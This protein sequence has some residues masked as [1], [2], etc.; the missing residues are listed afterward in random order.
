MKKETLNKFIEI[1]DSYK[2][3]YGVVSNLKKDNTGKVRGDYKEIK[4]ELTPKQFENHLTGKGYGLRLIALKEN[5]KLRYAALDLDKK[6]H[7]S[8]LKHS[9]EEIEKKV[10]QLGL[11][12]IPCRSKSGDVHL[13]CFASEDVDAEIFMNKMAE[14]AGLLGYGGCERFPKQTKRASREDTGLALNLPYFNHEE[15]ERY[16]IN[17]GKKLSLEEFIKYANVSQVTEE[18]LLNFKY[19]NFDESYNDAPPC[20]QI[21]TTKQVE[22]GGRNNGLFSFAVYYA[23][24]YPDNFEEKVMEAN[25]KYFRPMLSLKEVESIIKSVNKKDFFYKCK[26]SPCIDYCNKSECYKRRY[27]I[28]EIS[29]G[30]DVLIDNL[31]QYVSMGSDSARWYAECLGH[32]IQFTIEELFSQKLTRMKIANRTKKIIS[33]MSDIKWL[34][35]MEKLMTNSITIEDPEDA[36]KEGQFKELL[37]DWFS[38]N[39]PLPE[40]KGSLLRKGIFLDSKKQRIYFRSPELF[41]YLKN[42]KFTYVEHDIWHILREGLE[43]KRETVRAGGTVVKSWSIKA[44]D[45]Y[46]HKAEEEG[47]F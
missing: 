4:G 25:A 5:C 28:G 38:K 3:A 44:F 1:F 27:G 30:S 23:K 39:T 18:E 34:K 20:L 15:T 29:I 2:S 17:K 11:P 33:P 7:T 8:P 36:S 13:Y 24:K 41:S 46:D 22:D 14:W 9:I 21:L 31:T 37:F 19:E 6:C 12:L 35:M 40:D 16:A 47:K 42:K 45:F 43:G 10:K 32:R 26:E